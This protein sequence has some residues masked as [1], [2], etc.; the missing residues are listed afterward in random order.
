MPSLALI[1]VLYNSDSVLEDFISGISCQDY[2]DY[3]LYIVDNTYNSKTTNYLLSLIQKYPIA[4]YEHIDS[5]GNIGVAAGNNLGLHFAIK[6][7]CKT[8]IFL[9]NDIFIPQEFILRK[10]ADLCNVHKIVTP[11]IFYHDNNL[12]WMAGGF[13]DKKKALGVHYGM[14]QKDAPQFNEPKYVTYAPTCFLAVDQ[15]V[16]NE[17][18]E[19]DERYFAYYDDTD[20]VY[21][22][23]KNGFKVWYEPTLYIHHKVSSSSGGDDSLFY[24]YYSNRN[25]LIFIRKHFKGLHKWYLITYYLIVRF[26]FYFLRYNREKQK[27]LLKAT[28]NGWSI[29][30]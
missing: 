1:T 13:L 27:Q 23:V 30:L 15:S 8:F 19:M 14:K 11:K 24:I 17:I 7:G 12:I 26:F 3:K 25:K 21:R 18:G 6:D 10:I 22:A 9:N 5:K 28:R 20:F 2:H 16:I 29:R 4:D